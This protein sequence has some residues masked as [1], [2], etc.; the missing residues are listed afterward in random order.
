MA[1]GWDHDVTKSNRELKMKARTNRHRLHRSSVRPFFCCGSQ[2]SL[3]S[4]TEL[5]DLPVTSGRTIEEDYEDLSDS[6]DLHSDF[7]RLNV[8]THDVELPTRISKTKRKKLGTKSHKKFWPTKLRAKLPASKRAAQYGSES[9]ITSKKA[10]KDA[11][12]CFQSCQ[13]LLRI[14]HDSRPLGGVVA[15]FSSTNSFAVDQRSPGIAAVLRATAAESIQLPP[16]RVDAPLPFID[17]FNALYPINDIDEQRIAERRFEMEH[18]ILESRENAF[19]SGSIIDLSDGP[20]HEVE[21]IGQYPSYGAMGLLSPESYS[22]SAPSQASCLELR[23]SKG[24]ICCPSNSQWS[25]AS[26]PRPQGVHTQIDFKHYLVPDMNRIVN[27]S[28]YWGIMDRYQAEKL[29]DNKPEGTFL[30][31]DS[32]QD[33]FLFSVS[34]RRYG[35]SLHARIEQWNH[36]FSFDSRDPGVFAT[37]SVCGLIEHYK[38]PS[39]CMFFEPMLTIPVHRNFPFSLQHMARAAITSQVSYDGISQLPLPVSLKEYLRFYFY[40]QKVR[41]RRFDNVACGCDSH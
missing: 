35:R 24:A 40:K 16:R 13:S 27:S 19:A 18:G 22:A 34:F 9:K 38:D 3:N 26:I 41:V 39:C 37:S 5:K 1:E 2:V 6:D 25:L 36:K 15:N 8:A 10:D 11:C 23:S 21:G 4:I 32:A 20:S 17:N 14:N 7:H 31:R 30:L 12:T 29:I 33:E 28:F